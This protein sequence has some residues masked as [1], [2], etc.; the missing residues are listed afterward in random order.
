MSRRGK[1]HDPR[2]TV[3]HT[4]GHV[5]YMVIPTGRVRCLARHSSNPAG[6]WSVPW[7]AVS[8]GSSVISYGKASDGWSGVDMDA[9]PLC[10]VAGDVQLDCL[11]FQPG[12]VPFFTYAV[13]LVIGMSW[14]G[15]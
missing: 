8:P 11:G 3:V 2:F 7:V 15:R 10:G 5:R 13:S 6:V 14:V 4:V 12:C 9:Y 1:S